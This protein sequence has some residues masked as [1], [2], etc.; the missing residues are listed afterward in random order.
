MPFPRPLTPCEDPPAQQQQTH[1][2][3]L[4]YPSY[5]QLSEARYHS[6]QTHG[7]SYNG[8]SPSSSS[9]DPWRP[10]PLDV[11]GGGRW[12]GPSY[13][14]S[15]ADLQI[16]P[17]SRDLLSPHSVYSLAPNFPQYQ[18]P[19]SPAYPEGHSPSRGAVPTVAAANIHYQRSMAMSHASF[20]HTIPSSR[21]TMQLPYARVPTAP[22]PV[23]YDVPP[24][25]PGPTIKTKRKR[26]DARQLEALNRAYARTAYPS[27]EQRQQLARHLDISPRRVQIWLAHAFVYT[28]CIISE[29]STILRFQNKRQGSRRGGRNPADTPI[30][31]VTVTL[32]PDTPPVVVHPR[33]S[34]APVSPTVL[35]GEP[36]YPSR[37]PLSAIMRSG[38]TPTPP[39]GR[40]RADIDPSRGY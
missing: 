18:S 16:P 21:G 33:G 7:G 22:S 3:Y 4:S 38:Q 31:Q 26:L 36:S 39:S 15:H 28:A 30:S 6:D 8:A 19:A 29:L 35:Y 32:P 12:Q 13:Y 34:P 23:P 24:K 9:A 2:P 40:P 17:T 20:D 14:P 37:S 10:P 27:T 11:T 1:D 25:I 5:Q